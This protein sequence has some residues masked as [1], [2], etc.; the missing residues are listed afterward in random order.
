MVAGM[1]DEE[2][3]VH[4]MSR[5]DDIINVAAHRLSTGI[6][7]NFSR[8]LNGQVVLRRFWRRI[9]VWRNVVLSVCLIHRKVVCIS[10]S[11]DLFRTRTISLHNCHSFSAVRHHTQGFKRCSA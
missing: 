2:G 1:I 9:M 4:I 11:S 6:P 10:R 5:S 8:V 3:Y 7:S